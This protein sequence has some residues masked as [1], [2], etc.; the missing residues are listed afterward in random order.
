MDGEEKIKTVSTDDMAQQLKG[1]TFPASWDNFLDEDIRDFFDGLLEKTGLKKSEVI[2]KTNLDRT[3]G[4]QI[5]GG[6]RLGKRD[7]YLR[8]ALAMSLDL[9]TTQRMLA[10]THGGSLHP[11]IKRDAAVIFAIN[12]NYDNDQT[13]VFMEKVGLLPLETGL[14]KDGGI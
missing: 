4:Y 2:R 11:L 9:S 7:Y 14:E 13:H 6:Q 1:D 12:H 8:I 10:V 5:M 3:Y